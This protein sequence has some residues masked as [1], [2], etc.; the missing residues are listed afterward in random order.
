ML[1]LTI[2]GYYLL[3]ACAFGVAFFLP[4]C[5]IIASEARGASIIERLM[6]TLAT[7]ALWPLLARKWLAGR[8]PNQSAG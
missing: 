6:W 7:I 5:A 4:G 8:S 2:A 1:F 3:A